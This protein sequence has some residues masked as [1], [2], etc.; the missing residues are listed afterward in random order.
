MR[1][2]TEGD[3]VAS[4]RRLGLSKYEAQVFIALQRLST[5]TARD[6]ARVAEVPRSQVYGAAESLEERGLIEVQQSNPMQYRAVDLEE[7]RERLRHE[8]EAE[9]SRA[10]EFLESV[11]G[12][13][14]NDDERQEAIWT[15]RGTDTVDERVD[16]LVQDADEYVVH[17]TGADGLDGD[18]VDALAERATDGVDTT[19]VS[20]DRA[21]LEAFADTDVRTVRLPDEL[22]REEWYGERVLVVDGDTVLV[23]VLGDGEVP[24][25]REETAFWSSE[26]GFATFLVQLIDGWFG[27]RLDLRR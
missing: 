26:T 12:S 10:F 1:T 24:A 22:V 16:R 3:A 14:D 20:T 2:M 25:I 7:A 9:H 11:A 8:I 19:V 21:V 15:L 23:S 13:L 27:D 18:V 6:V 5:S 17:G 4:L